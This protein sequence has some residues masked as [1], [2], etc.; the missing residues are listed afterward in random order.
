MGKI[1][2]TSARRRLTSEAPAGL[3]AGSLVL[4]RQA[5]GGETFF[6]TLPLLIWR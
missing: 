2:R 5:E 4:Q 6:N 3:G 1:E